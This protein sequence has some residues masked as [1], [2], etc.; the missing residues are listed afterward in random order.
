MKKNLKF[1]VSFVI[2]IITSASSNVLGMNGNIQEIDC[3][4]QVWREAQKRDDDY[5][6]DIRD[7]LHT[8][9]PSTRTRA[10]ESI[11]QYEMVKELRNKQIELYMQCRLYIAQPS[12]EAGPSMSIATHGYE[13]IYERFLNGVLIYR[14]NRDGSDIGTVALPIK[15]L[16]DPMDG[17]FDLSRCGDSGKYLIIST[18]YR[19]EKKPENTMKLEI[20]IA[21]RFLIEKELSSMAAHFKPI[22]KNWTQEVPVGIF[23]NWGDERR[24][25]R[26]DYL[27]TMDMDNLSKINLYKNWKASTHFHDEDG[28]KA[29]VRR[30][31][32]LKAFY[33]HFR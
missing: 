1:C 24:M 13:A 10:V 15:E 9:T 18:G 3:K 2:V 6:C 4:I 27:T 29:H 25:N 28:G 8:T 19:K 30:N 16:K 21:P 12:Y 32:G 33:V 7:K 14:P 11:L 17:T 26:Y 5:Y 31:M 20:W 23:W 22:M